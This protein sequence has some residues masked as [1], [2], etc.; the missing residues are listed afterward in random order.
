MAIRAQRVEMVEK[1][2]YYLMEDGTKSTDPDNAK[3]FKAPKKEKEEKKKDKKNS[4]KE[5]DNDSEEWV[6]PP[7][8]KAATTYNIFNGL[9]GRELRQNNFEGSVFGEVGRLWKEMDDKA[10]NPYEQKAAESALQHEERKKEIA[11]K[12][13]WTLEDGSKSTDKKNAALLKIKKKKK[14]VQ[15]D[16]EEIKPRKNQRQAKKKVDKARSSALSVHNTK[17]LYA[18]DEGE[19]EGI[20]LSSGSD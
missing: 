6:H 19:S 3:H 16:D 14:A 15:E 12:G 1:K 13:Y 10:K 2:G 20:D 9:K 17:T 7:P 11:K 18:E 8:P 5:E 4:K